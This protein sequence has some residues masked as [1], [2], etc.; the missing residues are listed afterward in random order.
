M[1]INSKLLIQIF[2]KKKLKIFFSDYTVKKKVLN[3]LKVLFKHFDRLISVLA[4]KK[5]YVSK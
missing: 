1:K 3:I 5:V 2:H 4:I